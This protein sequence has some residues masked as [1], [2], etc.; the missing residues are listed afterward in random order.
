MF[1]LFFLSKQM[2]LRA[3]RALCLR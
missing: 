3:L 1:I 2:F